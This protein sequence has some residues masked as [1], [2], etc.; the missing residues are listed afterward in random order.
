M[1]WLMEEFFPANP[2][3]RFVSAA[4]LRKMATSEVGTEFSQGELEILARNLRADLDELV[5]RPPSFARAGDRFLSL[6][7][8][9][10]VLAASLAENDRAG[11]RGPSVRVTL[12]YGPVTI[13]GDG[14]RTA[15]RSSPDCFA[16]PPPGLWQR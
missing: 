16:A 8:A 6:A 1:K 3:S 11:D 7:E 9:F 13:V 12:I 15:S 5:S 2:G 10:E 14:D 4:D